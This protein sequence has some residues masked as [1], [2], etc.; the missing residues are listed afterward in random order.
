MT[1]CRIGQARSEEAD[2]RQVS[3]GNRGPR[4]CGDCERTAVARN[5]CEHFSSNFVAKALLNT[6]GF[7]STVFSASPRHHFGAPIEFTSL[8]RG[9]YSHPDTA[10]SNRTRRPVTAASPTRL[11]GDIGICV[12]SNRRSRWGGAPLGAD[13]AEGAGSAEG[14][15][16]QPGV[17]ACELLK[18]EE[19][20]A[21]WGGWGGTH[22]RQAQTAQGRFLR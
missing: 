19:H 10:A 17:G 6:H 7:F 13:D 22:G 2:R 9:R 12:R 16:D 11:R 1:G 8:V 14:A 21:Y 20:K 4:L 18:E 5:R 15:E 3:N